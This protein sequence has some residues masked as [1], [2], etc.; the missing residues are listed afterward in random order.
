MATIKIMMCI[1]SN[2]LDKG[3]KSVYSDEM[4]AIA[5]FLKDVTTEYVDTITDCQAW[6]QFSTIDHWEDVE[7]IVFLLLFDS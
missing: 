1:I 4:E 2:E 7:E 5:H 6:H 3:A